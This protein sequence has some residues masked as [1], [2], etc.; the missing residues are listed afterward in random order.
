MGKGGPG[1]GLLSRWA[2]REGFSGETTLGRV[3]H[4]DTAVCGGSLLGR[5]SGQ[6]KGPE[7]GVGV[8]SLRNSK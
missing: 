3:E 5:G 6:C 2:V 4:M 1:D 7:G 8:V